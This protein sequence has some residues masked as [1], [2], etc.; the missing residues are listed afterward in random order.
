VAPLAELPAGSFAVLDVD[1]QCLAVA[2]C[3]RV[4]GSVH[5]VAAGAEL[6]QDVAVRVVGVQV[7]YSFVGHP[8]RVG[9]ILPEELPSDVACIYFVPVVGVCCGYERR[10]GVVGVDDVLVLGF[11]DLWRKDEAQLVMPLWERC[12]QS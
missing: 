7:L 6:H 1:M 5:A 12:R 11:A 9:R 4:V 8:R 10:S 2:L 3:M